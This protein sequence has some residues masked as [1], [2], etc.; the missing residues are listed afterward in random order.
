MPAELDLLLRARYPLIWLDTPEEQRAIDL[1]CQ[2]A[3]RLGDPVCG[4]S[5]TFGLHDLPGP[6]KGGSHQSPSAVVQH[7]VAHDRRALWVLHDLGE[8]LT[9]DPALQRALRDAAHAARQRGGVIVVTGNGTALPRSLQGIAAVHRLALPERGD[10]VRQLHQVAAQCNVR[11]DAEHARR[12]ATATL[13][14]TLEQAEN[15]WARIHASGG[16]FDGGDLPQ[17]LAEKARIVRETGFLDFVPPA[18]LEDIGGLAHLKAWL[19]R[20]QVAFT[21]QARAQGLPFPRGVLL[22]GV[23][24]CGKSLTAKAVAGLWGQPLLRLDVGALMEGFVGAS[25]GNLRRALD[26]ADRIAPCVLWVDE[27][28]K[29]LT[30][31]RS[32][33]DGG[34]LTRMFGSMLTWMQEKTTPTFVLATANSIEGLPPEFLRKGRFDEIFFVDLPDAGQRA[35]IWRIHLE[36][37]AKA[38][39]DAALLQRTD[40]RDLAAQSEGYSGAEIAAA[41]VE[42]AFEALTAG[43]P[44]QGHHVTRALAASP[45]LSRL[46]A[47]SLEALRAW[48]RGRARSA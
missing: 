35:D 3:T 11:L 31:L 2:T 23:Q 36:A 29:A 22:V 26:L 39:G 45:P 19:S 1:I 17:V 33:N 21:D 13:G 32:S 18:R 5:S 10:Q 14:L 24:G 47:E 8:F 12:L 41:V 16:R 15:I 48:A 27:I 40:L 34:V 4:W 37:R 20:R 25:E 30:G 7:L 9:H 46:H 44:L 38:S 43:E 42:G 6:P 28:E